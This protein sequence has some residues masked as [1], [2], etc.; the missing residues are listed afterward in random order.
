MR[1][2]EQMKKVITSSKLPQRNK[3]QIEP[4]PLSHPAGASEK[5]RQLTR[6]RMKSGLRVEYTNGTVEANIMRRGRKVAILKKEKLLGFQPKQM[7]VVYSLGG[8]QMGSA[9]L[10]KLKDLLKRLSTRI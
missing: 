3:V 9:E 2:Q 5:V 7:W 4:Y 1:E 10:H 6:I 8:K